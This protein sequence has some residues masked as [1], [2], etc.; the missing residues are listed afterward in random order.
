MLGRVFSY[1]DRDIIS[2]KKSKAGRSWQ[3]KD[4]KIQLLASMMHLKNVILNSDCNSNTG[5]GRFNDVHILTLTQQISR[6]EIVSFHNL[7]TNYMNKN[8]NRR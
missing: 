4:H 8:L 2:W 5:F 7:E 3:N 1:D 6:T